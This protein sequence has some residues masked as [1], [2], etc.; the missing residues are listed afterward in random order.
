MRADLGQVAPAEELYRRAI[1]LDSQCTEAWVGLARL[2]KQTREDR[3][4]LTEAQL[5]VRSGLPPKKEL[6]LR[7]ALGK[8][9]DDM[10]EYIG[11]SPTT[12]VPT[13]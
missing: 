12:G 1:L 2:R 3:V 11:H 8:A 6:L 5:I 9:M 7:Y 4:W 10:G 13:S